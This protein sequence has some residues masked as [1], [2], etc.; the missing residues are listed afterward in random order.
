MA[1]IAFL[2]GAQWLDEK[3]AHA[4]SDKNDKAG[5]RG[6]GDDNARRRSWE[7]S[8]AARPGVA[9]PD[10]RR[11]GGRILALSQWQQLERGAFFCNAL[12]LPTTS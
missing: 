4:G 8:N 12:I 3:A 1:G 7:M 2:Q 9:A 5:N 10:V 11:H 6:G